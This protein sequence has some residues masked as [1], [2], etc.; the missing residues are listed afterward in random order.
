MWLSLS[1]LAFAVGVLVGRFSVRRYRHDRIAWGRLRL[2]SKVL[3]LE[4]KSLRSK[5]VA[6]QLRNAF[7]EPPIIPDVTSN[8]AVNDPDFFKTPRKLVRQKWLGGLHSSY[9]WAA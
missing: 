6:Q 3:S 5:V 8:P 2:Q 4:V 1:L 9:H 7:M